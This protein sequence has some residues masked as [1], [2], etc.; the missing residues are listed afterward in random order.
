MMNDEYYEFKF[1]M[2]SIVNVLLQGHIDGRSKK[3][4][5]QVVCSDNN[6]EALIPLPYSSIHVLASQA[7]AS[8]MAQEPAVVNW[9]GFRSKPRTEG[10]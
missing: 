6:R 5:R 8:G 2:V 7:M 10:D 1:Q 9:K 4:S 3:K